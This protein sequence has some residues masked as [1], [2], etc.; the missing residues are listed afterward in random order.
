MNGA[1][2]LMN[3]ARGASMQRLSLWGAAYPTPAELGHGGCRAFLI[4]MLKR[5]W[6]SGNK[7]H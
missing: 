3:D 2:F 1:A 5:R 6:R 4:R 7:A